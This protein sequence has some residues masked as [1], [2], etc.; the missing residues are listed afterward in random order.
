M[1][2]RLISFVLAMAVATICFGLVKHTADEFDRWYDDN[3]APT[4]SRL[5]LAFSG[6]SGLAVVALL[7]ASLLAQ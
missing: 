1:E 5:P 3:D 4:T 6:L 7:A 2:I